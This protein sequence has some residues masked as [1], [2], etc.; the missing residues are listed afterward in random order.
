MQASAE[1]LSIGQVLPW[2]TT[3]LNYADEI[4]GNIP[5]DD[6]ELD[7]RPDDGCGGWY[8][9]IREQAM[10]IAD[11]RHYILG[12]ITGAESD[13][14]DFCIEYGGTDKPWQF[15]RASRDEIISRMQAGREALNAWLSQPASVLL[16]SSESLVKQH[17]K[18]LTQ[19][20]EA[21]KDTAEREARGPSRVVN[22]L[23]FL[24]AHEQGHRSVLQNMLRQRGHAVVR[25][26]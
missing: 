19:L 11:T 25:Y 15:K 14:N 16:E 2:A 4:V 24:V 9:S 22:M 26:A 7:W 20:R 10:H 1:Q 18:V 3:F 21:G 23:L 13:A 12:S 17:E 6:A 8:F 5:A